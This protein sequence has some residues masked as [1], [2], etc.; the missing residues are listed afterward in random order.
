MDIHEDMAD[1]IVRDEESGRMFCTKAFI[2]ALNA[3]GLSIDTTQAERRFS[4][5]GER[6]TNIYVIPVNT[7]IHLNLNSREI[8][9]NIEN[10]THK[11]KNMLPEGDEA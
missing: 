6:S 9:D 11:I 1:Y 3:A 2:D 5:D 4:S 8:R 10:I 7:Y